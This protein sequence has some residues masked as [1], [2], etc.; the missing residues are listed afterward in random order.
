MASASSNFNSMSVSALHPISEKLTRTNSP[1]WKAPVLSALKGAQLAEFMEDK[2]TP[3]ET[4]VTD[5]KKMKMPNPE[6]AIYVARSL[7]SCCLPYLKI[8]WSMSQ[9]TQLHKK[10][11]GSLVSMALSQSQSTCDQHMDVFVYDK[12]RQSDD[13]PICWEDEGPSGQLGIHGQQAR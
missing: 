5:D 13:C 11:W 3:V 6:F 12:K 8:C 1:M 10:V 4:L 9:L 2:V 7:I